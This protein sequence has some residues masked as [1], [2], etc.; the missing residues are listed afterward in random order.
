[1]GLK[2]VLRWDFEIPKRVSY[3]LIIHFQGGNPGKGDW[4]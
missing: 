1:M 4:F 3:S 2:K